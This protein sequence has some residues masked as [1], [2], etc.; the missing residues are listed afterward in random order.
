MPTRGSDSPSNA[1]I[2]RVFAA[3]C[4]LL[5]AGLVGGGFLLVRVGRDRDAAEQAQKA[6]E[7][8]L[9]DAGVT[10][11]TPR[12]RPESASA[13]RDQDSDRERL[14]AMIRELQGRVD[15]LM[16]ASA[17]PRLSAAPRPDDAARDVERARLES[18]IR[19]LEKKLDEMASAKTPPPAPEPK[20][21]PAA[22]SLRNAVASLATKLSERGSP[23]DPE[24]IRA[25]FEQLLGPQVLELLEPSF[26]DPARAE[27]AL[28]L[29]GAHRGVRV[30][31]LVRAL[32]PV[33]RTDPGFRDAA[34]AALLAIAKSGD[35]D[36]LLDEAS[37]V[38]LEPSLGV[39]LLAAA[40]RMDSPRAAS[41]IASGLHRSPEERKLAV[42]LL[43]E[44]GAEG[45]DALARAL[46]GGKLPADSSLLV[47]ESLLPGAS[48]SEGP[49]LGQAILAHDE[50]VAVALA[51]RINPDAAPGIAAQL[52][53]VTL[54]KDREALLAH[55]LGL[56][57]KT[58]RPRCLE[59]AFET[60]SVSDQ[61]QAIARERG[62][63]RPSSA[64][65]L[66]ERAGQAEPL[67]VPDLLEAL[68]LAPPE[69]RSGP[70]AAAA[71]LGHPEG[72]AVLTR[73]SRHFDPSVRA[74][75]V[76]AIANAGL[77][78]AGAL[79]ADLLADDD[80]AVFEAAAEALDRLELPLDQGRG[81][82]AL[83]VVDEPFSH[84]VLLAMVRGASTEAM[85]SVVVD[86]LDRGAVREV[87]GAAAF[88]M[89]ANA[90]KGPEFPAKFLGHRDPV[91]RAAALNAIPKPDEESRGNWESVFERLSAD[92]DARVRAAAARGLGRIKDDLAR[93]RL[94]VM[95]RDP[96]WIVR[97]AAILGLSIQDRVH[98]VPVLKRAQN[99][100][101]PFVA[102]AARVALVRLGVQDPGPALVPDLGDP[103]YGG[104]SKTALLRLIGARDLDE[105]ALAAEVERLA[106]ASSRP[107]RR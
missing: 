5:L 40:G 55:A 106:A 39:P 35:V 12:P 104:R 78:R 11:S 30:P 26:R 44:R 34:T 63:P 103:A 58:P 42:E 62:R 70:A 29:A 32:A 23:A 13:I 89:M 68:D 90:D 1:T 6:A 105:A 97:E 17:T 49:P 67:D 77:T 18:T 57:T 50:G 85:T 4:G 83:A 43:L 76:A 25:G 54:T 8:K 71:A 28:R 2:A 107:G 31:A 100:P 38:D 95:V 73:L 65:E 45:R 15:E 92:P 16:Q 22:E 79:L 72:L 84:F 37:R 81:A 66:L 80:P 33:R 21:D 24:A 10:S 14:T 3:V 51:A 27:G 69:R 47:L 96:S 87:H 48:A 101:E 46:A 102:N 52:L 94:V 75:V 88:L 64:D 59:A 60:A 7:A 20:A 56:D 61:V 82:A 91:V 99:D 86:A 9:R 98:V 93:T 19:G 41:A 74:A 36:G 53:A